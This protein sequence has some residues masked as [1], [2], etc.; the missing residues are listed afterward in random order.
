MPYGGDC[1]AGQLGVIRCQVCAGAGEGGAAAACESAEHPAVA[2]TSSPATHVHRIPFTGTPFLDSE[3][4]RY[5]T[6][7]RAVPDAA[8]RRAYGIGF[9]PS[10]PARYF[11]AV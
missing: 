6:R 2:R 1:I 5:P 11:C 8:D 9:Q 7:S 4:G 10:A 3:R